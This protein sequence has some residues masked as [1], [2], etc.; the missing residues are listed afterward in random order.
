MPVDAAILRARRSLRTVT[1]TDELRSR[2]IAHHAL[3][4]YSL[5]AE[6]AVL[7]AAPIMKID[8][9]QVHMG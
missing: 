8:A 4:G 6:H 2:D 7:A 1:E 3:G 9:E 5:P